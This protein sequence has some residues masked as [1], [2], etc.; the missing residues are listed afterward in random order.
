MAD[1][2][3]PVTSDA[4]IGDVL[5]PESRAQRVQEIFARS[6]HHAK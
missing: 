1:P 6:E 5:D 3:L 4:I 2:Q